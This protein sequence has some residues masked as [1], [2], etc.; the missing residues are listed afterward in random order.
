MGYKENN[1]SKNNN[2]YDWETFVIFLYCY[3]DLQHTL[4][5]QLLL[6]PV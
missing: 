5:K 6:V 1:R 2:F 3:R 4:N